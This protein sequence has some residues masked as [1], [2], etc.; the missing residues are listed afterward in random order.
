M[1]AHIEPRATGVLAM[2]VK[3]LAQ[4]ERRLYGS[5]VDMNTTHITMASFVCRLSA[6]TL[7]CD[8]FDSRPRRLDA[9][10]SISRSSFLT[11]TKE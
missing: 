11:S 4:K 2:C 1:M 3:K 8:A 9:L 10:I 6:L 7:S 5:Q